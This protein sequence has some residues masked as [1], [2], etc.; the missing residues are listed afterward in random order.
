MGWSAFGRQKYVEKS[1]FSPSP[2]RKVYNQCILPV[3]T[4][5]SE[6]YSLT[7]VLERKITRTQ[8]EIKNNAWY[9]MDR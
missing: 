8:K 1:N 9:D 4:Y 7:E 2:K 5:E 3:L 6:T